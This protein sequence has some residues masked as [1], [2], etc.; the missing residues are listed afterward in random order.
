AHDPNSSEMLNSNV[1]LSIGTTSHGLSHQP[2][3]FSWV[4]WLGYSMP[5]AGSHTKQWAP[6]APRSAL[7][8]DRLML[9]SSCASVTQGQTAL[10]GFVPPSLRRGSKFRSARVVSGKHKDAK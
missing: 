6:S 5:T 8:A 4:S 3:T 7:D 2:A 10:R 9:P 1:L